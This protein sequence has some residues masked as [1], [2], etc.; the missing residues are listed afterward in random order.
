[1]SSSEPAASDNGVPT[2]DRYGLLLGAIVLSFLMQGIA[3]S[4]PVPDL[5]LAV[6]LAATLTLAL[7]AADARPRVLQVGGAVALAGIIWT[8]VDVATGNVNGVSDRI[9]HLLLVTLAPPAIVVGVARA[10][11]ARQAI[12]VEAVFGT[13][14]LYLLLGMGFAFAYGIVDKL[15]YPFFAQN[16]K[17]TPSNLL[18]F[19]FTTLTTVGYGDFT[20]R[21]QLGHTLSVSEAL[22]GQIYLVTVVSA[23]V[24]NLTPRRRVLRE[25]P[26]D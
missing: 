11:R 9:S 18:Y 7:W 24:A 23:I 6:L 5:A 4:G 26:R 20:A 2:R 14:C 25:P 12:T 16:A 15:A 13:L 19:S 3:K 22:A 21:T 1:M 17:A 10:V 8:I